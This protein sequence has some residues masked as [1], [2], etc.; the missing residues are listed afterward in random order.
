MEMSLTELMWKVDLIID[1]YIYSLSKLHGN[2]FLLLQ[3]IFPLK[4]TKLEKL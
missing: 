1:N 2:H 3:V 4:E